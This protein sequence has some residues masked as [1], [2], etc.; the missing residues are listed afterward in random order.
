MTE[1]AGYTVPALAASANQT[2]SSWT[3]YRW[4]FQAKL[5][6]YSDVSP[7]NFC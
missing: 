5:P 4:K 3:H 1:D 6:S 2:L 7:R